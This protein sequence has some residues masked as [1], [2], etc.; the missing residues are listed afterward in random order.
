MVGIVRMRGVNTVVKAWPL[1]LSD[2]TEV[3]TGY[4][5]LRLRLPA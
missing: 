3:L 1:Q 5:R 4:D 2:C